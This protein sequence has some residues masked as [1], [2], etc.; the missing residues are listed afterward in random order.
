MTTTS[1]ATALRACASGIYTVEAGIGLLIANGTLLHRDDFTS[2]FVLTGTSASDSAIRMAAIDWDAVATAL[3]AGDLPCSIR[4]TEDSQARRQPRRRHPRR[5]PRRHHRS[6]PAQHPAAGNRHSSRI[7]TT[8]A[9]RARNP[10]GVT[11]IT[12]IGG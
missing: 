3:A 9:P 10:R 4:R 8:T 6:R 7:W 1:L 12:R 11:C 5:P 2:R